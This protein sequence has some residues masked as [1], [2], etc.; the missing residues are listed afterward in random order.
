MYTEAKLS[1]AAL[2]IQNKK[3]FLKKI[4]NVDKIRSINTKKLDLKQKHT[5]KNE[6]EISIR[7]RCTQR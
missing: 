7:R 4:E 5:K 2:A 1:F 3:Q 6:S